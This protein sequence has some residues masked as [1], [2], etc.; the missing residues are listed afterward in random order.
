MAQDKYS[1]ISGVPRVQDQGRKACHY[2]TIAQRVSYQKELL[3]HLE[4][5]SRIG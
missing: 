2:D 4:E 3:P 1:I 5:Q